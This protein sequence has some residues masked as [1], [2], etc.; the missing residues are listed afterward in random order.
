MK[1][2]IYTSVPV[3]KAVSIVREGSASELL[4]YHVPP[5]IA[6]QTISER[7]PTIETLNCV[8]DLC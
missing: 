8:N 1:P 6:C 2:Y 7:F 5:L 4:I 3:I